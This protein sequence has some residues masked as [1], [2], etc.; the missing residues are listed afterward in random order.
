LPY[1]TRS[2]KLVYSKKIDCS[3][4]T[5]TLAG[6]SSYTL[7]LAETGYSNTLTFSVKASDVLSVVGT[8]ILS[9]KNITSEMGTLA[10]TTV[11]SYEYGVP[12]AGVI[13]TLYNSETSWAANVNGS[14]PN[15][16]KRITGTTVVEQNT[17]IGSNRLFTFSASGEF[18]RGLY[19]CYRDG[20]KTDFLYG[21]YPDKRLHMK[22]GKYNLT[23]RTGRWPQ[24]ATNTTS[25]PTVNCS[26]MGMD[27]VAI[28]SIVLSGGVNLTA[29]NIVVTGSVINAL[30]FTIAEEK[31]YLLDF[32][33]TSG[34]WDALI[35]GKIMLIN[36]PSTSF[37]YNSNLT[38][39]L[40]TATTTLTSMDSSIYNGVDKTALSTVIQ[41]YAGFSSTAPS[42]YNAAIADVDS[43][44]VK[45]AAYKAKV[46]AHFASIVTYH[47]NVVTAK[48]TLATYAGGKYAVLSAFPKLGAVVAIYDG[49]ELT[50]DDALK[51]ANDTL[52]FCNNL[53]N[54]WV[55]TC[56]PALKY[57]INKALTLARS[58]K[59]PVPE[60]DLAA[61]E[62]LLT[63]ND[64][65]AHALNIKIKQYLSHN[66][67]LD[68]LK[69]GSSLNDSTAKD[70]VEM[71][72]FIKNPNFYTTQTVT[73]LNSNTFPGWMAS[74]FAASGIATLA[75]P[76][77]PVSDT[78]AT[79][80]NAKIDTFQQTV[81]G[82]PNGVYNVNMH[83]R[84]GLVGTSGVIQADIDKFLR[85][86]VIHGTDT[87]YVGF[88]QSSTF[89]IPTEYVSIRKVTLTDGDSFTMGIKTTVS[90]FSGYTP[91]LFWG[92]PTIWLVGKNGTYTGVKETQAVKGAVKDVQYYTIQGFRM[93]APGRGLNIVRTI[94]ENGSVE[95]QK[96]MIK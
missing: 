4:V 79:V 46:D 15:G 7:N 26:I 59:V 3:T 27:T 40:N 18:T 82:L 60:S 52:S 55:N 32:G 87:T 54:N 12:E 29:Q 11:L 83:V 47:A 69:L 25:N 62:A 31:D 45:G 22:P 35:S 71:T 34:S 9:V 8:Y 30:N 49:L 2:F 42:A 77:S 39:K 74:N 17:T 67:A 76:V 78:Y 58:L 24:T 68:S 41:K 21:L 81:T 65:I 95:V 80:F 92:D 48:A 72:C 37:L 66:L 23:V 5:A 63:D 44:I 61:A 43:F 89:G 96:I 19:L 93:N 84:T 64:Q 6:P 28:N 73:G 90:P 13:D 57:R 75:T 88:K 14:I 51:V 85:F 70:S 91:S 50:N 36:T 1:N 10:P 94:Y 16:F 38:L 86:Y 20:V 33:V 56:I 53:M